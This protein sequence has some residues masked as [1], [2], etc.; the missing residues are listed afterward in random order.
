MIDET[1][2]VALAVYAHPDDADVACGGTLARWAKAG[3][4]VHLVVCTDG[5]KGTFDPTVKSK[6]LVATR[7]IELEESSALI[8]LSSVTNLGYPDGELR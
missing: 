5:G 2:A 3:S 1:P 8:G 7:A 4:A 6:K